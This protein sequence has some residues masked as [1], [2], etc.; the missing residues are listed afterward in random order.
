MPQFQQQ[1]IIEINHEGSLLRFAPQAGG[2]LL[3]WDIDGQ[4]VIFWPEHADWS[5]PARVRG[6]NPLLF[7]FL[8]RHFVDGQIGRW[9][10]AQGTVRDLPMHGFARDLPFEASVG[11]AGRSI[12]MTLADSDATRTGYPF[13]FRFEAKYT[14]TDA[15]AL[16]VDFVVTNT[17]AEGSAPLPYYAGHHFYFALPHT[18]RGETVLEL[19]RTTRRRQRPDGSL[20]AP[21]AGQPDY[22]L[23]DQSIL[24]CFHCLDGAPDHLV[25]VVALGLN[26]SITIDLQRPN[27]VPWFA[28]TTWTEKPES[29]FFCVEPWLGLPDAIHNG[30]GLRWVEPGETETASLRIAVGT[31]P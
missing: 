21:E 17:G 25:R 5:N 19:P 11:D 8:G 27:S 15:H 4:P 24:D 18:Q 7:P 6:G 29:D 2:R 22:R 28:V 9:K 10:D 1:D 20:T 3:S 16:D 23:D 31:L 13:N 12:S 30:Q 26:R 14:L